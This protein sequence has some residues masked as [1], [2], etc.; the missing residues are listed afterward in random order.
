MKKNS[1]FLLSG[2][3]LPLFSSIKKIL[4]KM[5]AML[6]KNSLYISGVFIKIS[7]MCSKM[8]YNNNKNKRFKQHIHLNFSLKEHFFECFISF[9]TCYAFE[10]YI[11]TLKQKKLTMSKKKKKKK[12]L[13]EKWKWKQQKN[14]KKTV[15]RLLYHHQNYC[16][17]ESSLHHFI[18]ETSDIH[19]DRRDCV[20]IKLLFSKKKMF[21]I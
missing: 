12:Y 17:R 18:C 6:I 5:F 1:N 9:K 11:S 20:R 3:S 2:P 13:I 10:F 8:A 14:E 4:L 21:C 16:E 19:G 7:K 15:H